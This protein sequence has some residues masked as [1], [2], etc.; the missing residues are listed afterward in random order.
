MPDWKSHLIIGLL[1][2]TSWLALFNFLEHY[3][4]ATDLV[5]ILFLVSVTSLFPDVDMRE[6]KIRQS[7]SVAIAFVVALV[8]LMVSPGTWYYSIAYFV[9]LYFILRHLPTKHRGIVHTFGFSLVF[10]LALTLVVFTFKGFSISEF[11][12]WYSIVLSGYLVH[13]AVDGSL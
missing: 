4:S 10:S 11:V 7:V 13:L 12:K 3:Q 1:L 8:Y 6:S 2:T 9:L 5:I